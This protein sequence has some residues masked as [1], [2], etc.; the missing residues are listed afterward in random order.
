MDID[1]IGTSAIEIS[2]SESLT[3]TMACCNPLNQKIKKL[4]RQ[5][6]CFMLLLMP[7]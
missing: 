1:L 6:K 2:I 7:F 3:C 4:S 5:P